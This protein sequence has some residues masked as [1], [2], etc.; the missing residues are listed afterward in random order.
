MINPQSFGQWLRRRRRSLDMTQA[1]LASRVGCSPITIRKMEADELRPSKQMAERLA[2]VLGVASEDHTS[3]VKLAR[4]GGDAEPPSL[5]VLTLR[6]PPQQPAHHNLPSQ[7]TPLLGRDNEVAAIQHLLR[8]PDVRLVTLTGAGGIGKTRLGLEIATQLLDAFDHGVT[9]VNL[10]PISDPTLVA[11]TL[12]QTLD[13]RE[14]GDR[15]IL[16]TLKDYLRDK[17]ILLL[18]DNFEQVV[19]AAPAVAE[20]LAG[21]PKAKVLATSRQPLHVRGEHEF[22][23]PPLATPDPRQTALVEGLSAYPAVELFVQR[24]GSV[25]PSFALTSANAST[26]AEICHRLDGLPLAIELAAARVKVFSPPALLQR[27][28]SRLETLTVGPRD[29][30]ER[31]QT[32]R[33]AIGW[34]Y[35]LLTDAE[36]ALFRRL[37]VFVGGFTLEAAEAVCDPDGDLRPGVAESVGSLLDKSLLQPWRSAASESRFG[38]L[39]TIREYA[40]EQLAAH[41]ETEAIG[42]AHAHYFLALAETAEP[43]L[44][45]PGQAIW[46]HRLAADQDNLRAAQSWTSSNGKIDWALRFAGAL[47]RFWFFRGDLREGSRFAEEVL[48]AAGSD[49]RTATYAKA[50]WAAGWLVDLQGFY[51]R[52]VAYA[53]SSAQI[54]MELGDHQG[55]AHSLHLLAM[56]VTEQGDLARAYALHQQTL[57]LFQAIGD[58]RGATFS[59]NGLGLVAAAQG[60]Y[61]TARSHF[62]Q[63]AAIRRRLGDKSFL[64]YSLGWLAL[65]AVRLGDLAAARAALEEGVAVRRELGDEGGL[66]ASCEG[67]AAVAAAEGRAHLAAR[68]FGAAEAARE[69]V[70][71]RLPPSELPE[72]AHNIAV[73]RA[74]MAEDEFAAAYSKGQ[75]MTLEQ[76]VAY[77]LEATPTT[78]RR[79]V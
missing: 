32:L 21:S 51:D 1:E 37:G 16:A 70:G 33:A 12:A 17:E 69:R 24:A 38:M 77:A 63:C 58:E 66:A 28:D 10:A 41:G 75:T 5:S 65:C 11:S 9:F 67:L 60:D 8:R 6:R 49:A 23:V 39:E 35:D 26:V 72:R 59:H 68:L 15:P 29:A 14:Q 43:E 44:P 27:L 62:E 53:E 56:M 52:S 34:S 20:L 25:Q 61:A 30:P 2:H 36:E 74:Q 73:A 79:G 76:A 31:Q 50:L 7:V 19:A 48:A 45:G 78:E 3:F 71:V 57:P 47:W 13:V 64:A 42:R 40:L 46:L 18:L 55:A 22:P 4:D 54:F